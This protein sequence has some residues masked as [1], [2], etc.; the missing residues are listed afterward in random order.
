MFSDEESKKINS[1][2]K[3]SNITWLA[4][5]VPTLIFVCHAY[6]FR[7]WIID[8]AGISFAY[9]RNLARG[10]GLVAQPGSAPVEGYSNFLWILLLAPFFSIGLFHPVVTPKVL[11]IVIVTA[12]FVVIHKTITLFPNSNRFL[13][14]VIL[15]LTAINSSF[16][17]WTTSGLENSLYVLML[18]L[19]MFLSIR[20]GLSSKMSNRTSMFL[21]LLVAGAAMTRPEGVIYFVAYPILLLSRNFGEKKIP[22]SP[23]LAALVCYTMSFILSFGGFLLFRLAYFGDMFPN[24]YR[25]KGGPSLRDVLAIVML[26]TEM[27]EKMRD[28][29]SSV[30]GG[31]AANAVVLGLIGLAIAVTYLVSTRHFRWEHF[32]LL[33]FLVLSACA[34]L[35][36]PTDWMA[37]YRFA[38]PFVVFFYA[39]GVVLAHVFIR[40]LSLK[41]S[42]RAFIAVFLI[43]IFVSGNA[44]LFARRSIR[45]ANSPSYPFTFVGKGY[46]LRLNRYAKELGVKRGSFLG[47][48]AGGVLYY[49]NL[50]FYDL[51]GLCDKSI[52]ASLGRDQAAFYNYVFDAVRPTFINTHGVWTYVANLDND[53]RFR[54]DYVSIFEY[55]D[56]Y[57][58]N[59]FG[60]TMYSGDYVRK[61]AIG[62]RITALR[63]MQADA[64]SLYGGEYGDRLGV[65]KELRNP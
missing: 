43:I 60:L 5:M 45:F 26:R 33:T 61:E 44:V 59:S 27:V 21:G 25:M 62:N 41:E 52:T 49:T 28:L 6:F 1:L 38:T 10:Y 29:A 53:K 18:S 20:S 56:D 42:S 40:N 35:L 9:A 47:P 31:L 19:L 4:V 30:V 24:T 58:R 15:G 51:G 14:F 13:T 34:Y 63:Q 39:F 50:R 7:A 8:D 12:A 54:R 3:S 36:L 17:I 57:V 65:P 32:A 37:L 64:K 2:R 16:V 48:D 23:I 22:R 46:G 55:P 11:S